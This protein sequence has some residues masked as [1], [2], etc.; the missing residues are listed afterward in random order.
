MGIEERLRRLEM[1]PENRDMQEVFNKIYNALQEADLKTTGYFDED[2]FTAKHG[3]KSDFVK[4]KL[5]Q[6]QNQHQQGPTG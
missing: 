6:W 5:F 4:Q 1:K 2:A 3:T